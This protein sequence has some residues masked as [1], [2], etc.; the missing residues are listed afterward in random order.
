MT[1]TPLYLDFLEGK[2]RMACTPWGSPTRN[3]LGWK[4]PC[5]LITD[6]YYPSFA[7]LMGK[8]QWDA[9]G[10]GRDGRCRDC[11]VHSGFEPAAMGEC[12]SHPRKMLRMLSVE[13]QMRPDGTSPFPD[14]RHDSAEA[15]F[16]RL[17][18]RLFSGLHAPSGSEAGPPL[19]RFAVTSSHGHP[20][21]L[22]YITAFPTATT[23][24]RARQRAG[25]SG[26]SAFR[27]W[28]P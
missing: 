5:Y 16:C 19:R 9:Y 7:E 10:P 11:M 22:P 14:S 17:F 15:L 2:G 24:I 6:T 23:I 8:T 26:S 3:P 12:F 1:G 28:T 18:A 21:T 20:N 25:N 27:S 4:S 13:H